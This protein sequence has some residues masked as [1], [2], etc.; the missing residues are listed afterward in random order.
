M[1]LNGS[2][3]AALPAGLLPV[4]LAGVRQRAS[5]RPV[6]RRQ[7]FHV[8]RV[9]RHE[10]Q[11]HVVQVGQLN[12][13]ELRQLCF[14]Q[15]TAGA[16]RLQPPGSCPTRTRQ[17]PRWPPTSRRRSP[18]SCKG[19]M[20]VKVSRCALAADARTGAVGARLE[21]EARPPRPFTK[22]IRWTRRKLSPR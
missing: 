20:G 16:E 15:V 10:A 5:I 22:R 11:R 9:P 1:S 17:L 18:R 19:T 2:R 14:C 21:D 3:F 8:G 12:A 6:L 7:R 4:A 13:E